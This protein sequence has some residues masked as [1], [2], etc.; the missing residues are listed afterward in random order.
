MPCAQS[1]LCFLGLNTLTYND[2]DTA[3]S[4]S[5]FVCHAFVNKQNS[6]FQLSLHQWWSCFTNCSFIIARTITSRKWVGG[7]LNYEHRKLLFGMWPAKWPDILW[8]RYNER[9]GVSNHQLHD[10]LPTGLFSLRSKKTLN[11]RATG[12]LW[13]EFTGCRWIPRIKGQ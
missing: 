3:V 9:D 4:H 8:R 10:C 2:V 5:T 1:W 6:I 11:L 13:G 12:L 7:K